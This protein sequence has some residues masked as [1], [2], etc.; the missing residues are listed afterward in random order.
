MSPLLSNYWRAGTVSSL[1]VCT[2]GE[3]EHKLPEWMHDSMPSQGANA[4]LTTPT[5][6][7]AG[8]IY[9]P[10]YSNAALIFGFFSVVRAHRP[11][12]SPISVTI[13]MMAAVRDQR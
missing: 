7:R 3:G 5:A 1:S 8:S 10:L 13:A 11:N 4:P 2:S 12:G 9:S 6:Y